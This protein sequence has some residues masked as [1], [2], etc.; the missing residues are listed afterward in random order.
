MCQKHGQ[1]PI[2]S[3]QE[4]QCQPSQVQSKHA[5]S[6]PPAQCSHCFTFIKHTKCKSPTQHEA[7]SSQIGVVQKCQL[8]TQVI[9]EAMIL[10]KYSR[11]FHFGPCSVCVCK[12]TNWSQIAM[13]TASGQ[14]E[15]LPSECQ[16]GATDV[17]EDGRWVSPAQSKLARSGPREDLFEAP[18]R[19]P[20]E[21]QREQ[22]RRSFA[23]QNW[24]RFNKRNFEGRTVLVR[25]V[26]AR[27]IS[28]SFCSGETLPE[29]TSGTG[30][31]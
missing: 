22:E 5:P 21:Q 13:A 12:Q 17:W 25:A 16:G 7:T 11:C 20:K 6:C 10:C 8:F 19:H 28:G 23:T 30:E 4:I 3:M 29:I 2:L 9:T 14:T 18:D 24:W 31:N 27:A 1:D 15:G 26:G